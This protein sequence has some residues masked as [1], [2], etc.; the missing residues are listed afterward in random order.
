MCVFI[1]L[2]SGYGLYQ[3]T[4]VTIEQGEAA[5]TEV[6]ITRKDRRDHQVAMQK[7]EAI[8]LIRMHGMACVMH[9]ES[10]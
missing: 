4:R 7:A 1:L 5:G 9:V 3:S 10:M 8:H 2:D 6:V